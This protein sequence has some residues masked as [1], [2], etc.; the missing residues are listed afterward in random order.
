MLNFGSFY[1]NSLDVVSDRDYIIEILYNI[2]LMMVYLLCFVEEIIFWF[3]DEVKFIIL[4]DVFLIG[5][6]IML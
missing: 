1:E 4:L 5:L 2:F 6:F 3:I